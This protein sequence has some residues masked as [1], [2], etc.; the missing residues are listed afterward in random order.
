M[1]E[2]VWIFIGYSRPDE[3]KVYNLYD[4]FSHEGFKPWLDSRDILPGEDWV[5]RV[6]AA[7]RGAD[8]FILCLSNNSVKENGSLESALSEQ[9]NLHLKETQTKA[10][11]IPVRLEECPVP[12]MLDSFGA[13]DLF[14]EDGW[15]GL[16]ES[17]NTVVRRRKG[18]RETWANLFSNVDITDADI[19][20]V[21]SKQSQFEEESLDGPGDPLSVSAWGIDLRKLIGGYREHALL[22]LGSVEEYVE[23]NLE[24]AIDSE[25][26]AHAFHEALEKL[27]QTWQPSVADDQFNI[28][29]LLDLI[30]AYTP[31]GGFNKVVELI[32]RIRYFEDTP[33][34]ED[35]IA[36]R[37]D[38]LLKAF[39]VLES[40]YRVAPKSPEDS[41]PAYKTYVDLLRG[42]LLNSKR[43]GYALRRLIE[44]KVIELKSNEI[45]LFIEKTPSV[46]RE[47]VNLMLDP[48]RRIEAEDDLTRVFAL[49]LSIG[50]EAVW[51]FV[52]AVSLCG[53]KFESLSEEYIYIYYRDQELRLNLSREALYKYQGMRLKRTEREWFRDKMVSTARR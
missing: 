36:S 38:L 46:L 15:L 51:E 1:K 4:Q 20:D 28:A 6:R 30:A 21:S 27:V 26:A 3:A 23:V 13:V 48:N 52:Q 40:Y 37:D 18:I 24:E 32:R 41:S 43:R 42:E 8:F 53:G 34:Y 45:K 2:T 17:I 39:V 22:H 35:I 10:Y 11:L 19:T 9:L 31:V 25:G 49:C 29:L 14:K 47:L 5:T 33:S 50:D 7:I 12:K 44:L 16:L